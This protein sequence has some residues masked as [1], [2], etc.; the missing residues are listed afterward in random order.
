MAVRVARAKA[1]RQQR[2]VL[3]E[4]RRSSAARHGGV[5]G[6][7][8]LGG[9]D[10]NVP[11]RAPCRCSSVFACHKT[12]PPIWAPRGSAARLQNGLQGTTAALAHAAHAALEVVNSAS[13][14]GAAALQPGRQATARTVRAAVRS[15]LPARRRPP[16]APGRR[17]TTTRRCSPRGHA[18]EAAS[19]TAFQRKH[20][21]YGG[22]GFDGVLA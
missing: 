12:T 10:A 9:H 17:R 4:G 21:P 19:A 16:P 7:V 8:V 6:E 18:Q 2:T 22:T 11:R 1:R 13:S 3:G 14:A 5:P 15:A 20:S